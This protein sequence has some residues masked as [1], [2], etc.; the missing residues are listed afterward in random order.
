[1]LLEQN[2]IAQ[3]SY[4]WDAQT[5]RRIGANLKVEEAV[6]KHK[7]TESPRASVSIRSQSQHYGAEDT[8]LGVIL[9][10]SVEDID[11]IR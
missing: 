8:I 5:A 1:M 7:T 6:V 2:R 9:T 10:A 3:L 4:V 11:R